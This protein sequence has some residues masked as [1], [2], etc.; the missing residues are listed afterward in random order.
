M[1][2]CRQTRDRPAA[3]GADP[4]LRIARDRPYS[5]SGFSKFRGLRQREGTGR[6]IPYKHNGEDKNY[7]PDFIIRLRNG[8]N[9]VTEIKGAGGKVF[10]PD[11][12]PAKAAASPVAAAFTNSP[13]YVFRLQ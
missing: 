1:W 10:D 3:S 7:E 4:S 6:T 9:L 13:R 8:V 2:R 11:S 12:V 5:G